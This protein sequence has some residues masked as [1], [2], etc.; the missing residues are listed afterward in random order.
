LFHSQL[1]FSDEG[2]NSR[3]NSLQPGEHDVDR[4]AWDYMRKALGDISVEA[5]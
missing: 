2:M 1:T 4:N 5:P 3:V